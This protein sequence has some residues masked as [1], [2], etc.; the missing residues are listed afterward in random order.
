[1]DAIQ[2]GTLF[3]Y[4][5]RAKL[6]LDMAEAIIDGANDRTLDKSRHGRHFALGDG[7]GTGTPD[8]KN[9]GFDFNGTTD[10]LTN[11]ASDGTYNND[12]QTIVIACSPDFEPGG[13]GG[14][15]RYLFDSSSGA[16]Y[17]ISHEGGGTLLLYMGN[18]QIAI[19]AQ[20]TYEPHWRTDGRNVLVISSESGD[21]DVWLNGHQILT[22][23]ATVWAKQDP[24]AI[25]IGSRF[26]V[27]NY[28]DGEIHHFSAYPFKFGQLQARDLTQRLGVNA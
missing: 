14:G 22:A 26:S 17:F 20:A 2:A 11:T 27:A 15:A 25:Y 1:V 19:I 9:P 13:G 8:F 24:A 6:W 7:V 21:T 18:T 23:N 5:Q 12:A 16:R 3:D 10:Y 28:F 4:E